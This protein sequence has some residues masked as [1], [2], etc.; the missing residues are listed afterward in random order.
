KAKDWAIV[1]FETYPSRTEA[2]ARERQIKKWK[3][4]KMVENLIAG[5]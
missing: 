5:D 2:Y 3:S 1:Y 4:R